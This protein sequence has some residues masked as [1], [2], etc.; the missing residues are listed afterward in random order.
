M[1]DEK[2]R[3]QKRRSFRAI[4]SILLTSAGC[5]LLVGALGLVLYNLYEDQ[6]AGKSSLKIL[7]EIDPDRAVSGGDKAQEESEEQL[8]I[9]CDE[10][11]EAVT[12][13]IPENK[14]PLFIDFPSM[15]M[16]VKVIDGEEYI[17]YLTIPSIDRELP[18]TSTW[19]YPLLRIAPGRYTGSVYSHDIVI[20]GHNY[21][22]HF[23]EIK[24]LQEGA[25]VFFT[26]MAGNR[27]GYSVLGVEQLEPYDSE[28]MTSGDW[29]L[30]FFTCTLGGAHRVTVR[31]KLEYIIYS[32]GDSEA[33]E[34]TET[35]TESES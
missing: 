6:F 7:D 29:D 5:L 34:E 14:V 24:N 17:G 35:E 2:I 23:G 26:D 22:R 33:A 21:D 3:G 12:G 8:L 13:M 9:R 18:V 1:M 28:E 15:E 19:S 10:E 20:C 4:Q 16:P 27:F 32:Q 25:E 31:C 11:G 30:T